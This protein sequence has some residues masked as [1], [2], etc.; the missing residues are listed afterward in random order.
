MSA[1]AGFLTI[2]EVAERL[3]IS[4]S[5]V[6]RYI[7]QGK[8][9]AVTVGQQKLIP[10]PALSNFHRNKRGRPPVGKKSVEVLL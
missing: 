6:A 3:G 9:S 10:E 7:R 2:Q 8:L 5:I 1:I 4:H